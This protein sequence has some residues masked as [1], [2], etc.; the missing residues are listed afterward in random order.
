MSNPMVNWWR[1]QQFKLSLKRGDIRRA[2]QQ[3]QEIQ[4]SGATFSWLEKLFR[5]KL[6]L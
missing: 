2:M 3:L 5:D 1:S 4:K 6:Q